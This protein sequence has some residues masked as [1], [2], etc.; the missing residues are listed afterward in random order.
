MKLLVKAL[1]VLI[2]AAGMTGFGAS[3]AVAV[4][5]PDPVCGICVT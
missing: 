4:S 1:L 2:V 5:T 3:A